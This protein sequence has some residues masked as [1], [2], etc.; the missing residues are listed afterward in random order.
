MDW[1]LALELRLHGVFLFP[2]TPNCTHVQQETD[3]NYGLFQSGVR[4]VLLIIFQEKGKVS[5]HHVPVLING[6]E[7]TEGRPAIESPYAR[8]FAK[9]PNH[10]IW[11]QKVGAAQATRACLQNPEVRVEII[12]EAYEQSVDAENNN[13]IAIEYSWN[14]SIISNLKNKIELQLASNYYTCI[15][16]INTVACYSIVS[17]RN[18]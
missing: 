10:K 16:F 11:N 15:I 4:A 6:R 13:Y 9:D 1:G 8:A 3:Q 18:S 5:R 14:N 17:T 2:S 12:P 7:A